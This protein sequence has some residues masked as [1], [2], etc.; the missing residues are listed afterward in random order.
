[1]TA[2]TIRPAR[3]T[4]APALGHI[5]VTSWR[6]AFRGIAPDDYLD[7]Q[8]S[9]E[10][11]IEDWREILVDPEQLVFVAENDQKVIGYAWAHREEAP[12]RE[13][14][15]ELV[16]MHLLPEFKRQGLGQKLFSAAAVQLQSLGC[17][18]V[19]LW[20]LEDNH[21]ARAFYEVL[22]GKLAG[23]HQI[24]LGEK[25]LSELAYG[26]PNISDL[27]KETHD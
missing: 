2:H 8:A 3:P 24:E 16:S 10:N 22:G 13:W 11:Q 4:D 26:W 12:D 23:Q 5:Q 21:A 17:R 6:S 18:S 19:Y 27:I 7:H 20:V 15:G 1:M 25:P 14:D 9:I